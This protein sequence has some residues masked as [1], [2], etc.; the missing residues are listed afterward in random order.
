MFTQNSKSFMN[1]SHRRFHLI[2]PEKFPFYYGYIIAVAGTLGVMASLP[3]QTVGVSTFTDPVKDALGLN[4]DQISLAYFAGTFMSSLFLGKAGKLFDKYGAR[5]LAVFAAVG[6]SLSLFLSSTADKLSAGLK[7]ILGIN[8]F[9]IPAVVMT[10]LFFLIRFTGQGVLTLAS[11][12]MIMKWFD[13]LRGRVNAFSSVVVSLGFSA[14]PLWID[15]LI[16]GHGWQNAWV[17]MGTGLIIMTV[18]FFV[19]FRDTPENFGLKTDGNYIP[20]KKDIASDQPKEQFTLEMAL[21]TRAF[22]M[23]SLSLCFY[24]FFV[25]GLTFHVVSVFETAGYDRD[26]AI[27]IFLPV[28][29]ISVSVS[30]IANYLSDFVKL[31]SYLYILIGG[32]V[33]A[34]LGLSTLALHKIGFYLII[35]GMG[36]MAGIFAVLISVT[37]PRF[38]GRKH[39]G[40]IS[41]KTMSM[42][43]VGSALA[44][45]LFSF[46]K[47]IFSTYAAVGLLSLAFL[48]FVAIGSIKAQNPQ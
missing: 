37:W 33:V 36:V 31:K 29:V 27:S 11:R 47:T 2:K 19:F 23:Y 13:K 1:N 46:S 7:N 6:L 44:P 12:N 16:V 4:R 32:G 14:S 21:K 24:S 41:G 15:K 38:Y 20:K 25:T 26:H 40:A 22:W 10:V 35:T 3:G 43:V 48:A 18:V 30:L 9:M 34:S 28:S 42:I 8:H 39:L 5:W 45:T 17:I